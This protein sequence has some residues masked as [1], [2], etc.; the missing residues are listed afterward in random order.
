MSEKRANRQAYNDFF[1]EQLGRLNPDQR[2]AV[3]H[4]EGPMLVIAGPGTGK[5][6]ILAAR[7]GRFLLETDTLPE[8][9][10]CL[11]FTDAGVLA[12]PDRLLQFIGTASHRVH[13]ATFHSFCYG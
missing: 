11:T 6:Q 7:I 1:L 9:I 5:T 10:L 8:N 13:L 2:R 4:F 12:M 3:D